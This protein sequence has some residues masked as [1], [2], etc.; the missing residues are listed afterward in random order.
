MRDCRLTLLLHALRAD[1]AS[2]VQKR[3]A[4]AID[5]ASLIMRSTPLTACI[6][7]MARLC[8]WCLVYWLDAQE[9]V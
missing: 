1:P 9:G 7:A 2:S 6:S 5:R 8:Q 3:R 4:D